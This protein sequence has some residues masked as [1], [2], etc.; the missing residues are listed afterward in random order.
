LH[1][2]AAT[3]RKIGGHAVTIGVSVRNLFDTAYR[4]YLNQFRYFSDELGRNIQ[5]RCTTVF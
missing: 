2:H 5:I 4:D 1:V 3:T